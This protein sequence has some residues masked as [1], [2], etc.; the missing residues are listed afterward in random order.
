MGDATNG[1]R[2]VTDIERP[3]F[4]L[5]P[6]ETRTFSTSNIEQTQ[7]WLSSILGCR[8]SEATAANGVEP[9]TLLR[10]MA[11]VGAI[12]VPRLLCCRAEQSAAYLA[13]LQRLE[14]FIADDDP[15]SLLSFSGPREDGKVRCTMLCAVL[16]C[17]AL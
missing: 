2:V 8:N 1:R 11:H 14:R 12:V 5:S 15:L 6:A 9:D 7:R 17:A 13:L 10:R 3:P 16:C 4:Q